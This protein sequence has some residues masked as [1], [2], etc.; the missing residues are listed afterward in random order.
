VG[1]YLGIEF[2]QLAQQLLTRSDPCWAL[3]TYLDTMFV[4][5]ATEHQEEAWQDV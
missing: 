5:V 1:G 3:L 4:V 2:S